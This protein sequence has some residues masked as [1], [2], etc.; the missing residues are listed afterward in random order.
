MNGSMPQSIGSN[1][2]TPDQTRARFWLG[3]GLPA[4]ILAASYIPFLLLRSELPD[5]V[6]SHYDSAGRG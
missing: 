3:V 4:A 6:A 1:P 2:N 5:R